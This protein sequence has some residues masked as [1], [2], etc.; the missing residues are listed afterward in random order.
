MGSSFVCAVE[1]VKTCRIYFLVSFV[2]MCKQMCGGFTI[3]TSSMNGDILKIMSE[4]HTYTF[5]VCRN[6]EKA[7]VSL[8]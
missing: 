6:V 4:S 2:H 8:K 1:R 3:C 7:Y 5:T